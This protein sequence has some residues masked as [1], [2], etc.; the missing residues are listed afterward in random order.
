MVKVISTA[1]VSDRE[2]EVL[3]AVGAHLSNA[4]IASKLFI[5]VRTVEGHVSSLL[6]KY[7]V[8]DR[9]ELAAIAGSMSS[10]TAAALGTVANLP[11]ARTSFIGRTRETEQVLA[12]LAEAT[13]VT[14]VGP[15]GVG[16]TRL[17]TVVAQLA[18]SSVPYA[19]VFVDL[20]PAQ[21]STVP[22]AVAAALGVEE[23]PQLPLE[24]AI[25][26][27]LS[28]GRSMLVLDNC[29]HVIEAVSEFAERLLSACPDM[30][31]LATS[32][33]RLGIAGERSIVLGPLPLDSDAELL[34]HDRALAA[35]PAF[36]FDA[37]LAADV[38]ARLDGLPLAIELAAARTSALG[39]AGLL[40]GLGDYLRL[41]GGSRTNAVRQRSLR[42]VIDWS[43]ELLDDDE[44][45]LFKQL[46]VFVG[47]FDLAAA[48]VVSDREPAVVADLLG[49]LVDKSLVIYERAAGRWRLLATIRAFAAEQLRASGD[50]ATIHRRHV[51]WAATV[52]G[53]LEKRITGQW[54]ED[55][56][57][58][59][60]NLRAALLNC[61]PGPDGAAHEL[62]R[63]LGHLTH[64]RRF[65]REARDLY[66]RAAEHAP[67]PGA[68]AQDLRSAAECAQVAHDS[69]GAFELLLTSAELAAEA[70]DEHTRAR[71]L[72]RAV[73]IACR[74]QATF[75]E[76]VS[77]ERLEQLLE[78]AMSVGDAHDSLVAARLAIAAAWNA[79][80]QKLTPQ[81]DL[82]EAA[83]RAARAADDP[84]LVSAALDA[85]RT[86][87]V[88]AGR[89]RD[90]YQITM[91][92]LDLVGA[93][94][95]SNPYD[96]SEIE[97][98]YALACY[99]CVAVG[100]LPRAL[101]IARL[102]LGEDPQDD[103]T[104]LSLSK[105]IPALVL[106]SDLSQMFRR[107]PD[108]WEG[109]VRAG[110]P[111]AVWLPVAAQFVALA[112]GLMGDSKGMA[113]WQARSREAEAGV[114]S[115][116][117]DRHGGVA[118]FVNARVAVHNGVSAKAAA[119]VRRALPLALEA[120][121]RSYVMAAQAEL[122]VVAGLADAPDRLVAARTAAADNAWATACVLRAEGRLRRDPAALA[123]SVE[124]WQQIDAH[125]ERAC[126]L[127]LLPERAAEG[128]A[129]LSRLG[130][131]GPPA[132]PRPER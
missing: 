70:G 79:G 130:V 20:V 78:T 105:A 99:D 109:W 69:G 116:F 24:A 102:I 44:K 131:P 65:L 128:R 42:A 13:L 49:R 117:H 103:Y 41:L 118:A 126:T 27:R 11:A 51:T 1:Q 53:E 22:Q 95:R 73:E 21:H 4:Q 74:Y 50:E 58:V 18:A 98:V 59:V 19:G 28:R 108:M 72:A 80:P 77:Y 113:R 110:R 93:M 52:A 40:T 87:A 43:H 2:A 16:K 75:A 104:Y 127:L 39:S 132:T 67:T 63:A 124:G 36:V 61:L 57:L 48:A 90:A 47:G 89:I 64:A 76:Q 83:V 82:A 88:T 31:I 9:R 84:V 122:A 25:I 35:D 129:E 92:R 34:F 5:S 56:D 100:N 55:F 123:E 81:H 85:V 101:E 12:L 68:A 125:F 94:E 33:E 107:G 91:Q 37:V 15:G 7:G 60:D 8:A 120:R 17:V 3:A 112:S 114:H 32:R 6:R 46:A 121:F 119:A 62:A 14:L 115:V 54:R 29:E 45:T 66:R 10:P 30:K 111:P 71:S 23:R 97:D 38:C 106:A 96:A 86:A 26:E